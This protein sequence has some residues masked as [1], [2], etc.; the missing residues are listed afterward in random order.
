MH[1]ERETRD[2]RT[3]T[4]KMAP[5]CVAWYIA[6][7][8]RQWIRSLLLPEHLNP[9]GGLPRMPDRQTKEAIIL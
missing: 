7:D 3:Q 4:M 6:D 1:V 2:G 8:Q 9:K 5:V